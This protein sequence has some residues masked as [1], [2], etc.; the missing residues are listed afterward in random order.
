MTPNRHAP[1]TEVVL[2]MIRFLQ[3][4]ELRHFHAVDHIPIGGLVP[5]TAVMVLWTE[6]VGHENP[7]SLLSRPQVIAHGQDVGRSSARPAR[8]SSTEATPARPRRG[9]R[10][11]LRWTG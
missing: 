6:K 3:I 11:D 9:S 10:R 2:R 4:R 1:R 7:L 5:V 8:C